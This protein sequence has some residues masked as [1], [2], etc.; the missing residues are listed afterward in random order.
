MTAAAATAAA[1]FIIIILVVDLLFSATTRTTTAF[2]SCCWHHHHHDSSRSNIG[3]S[4]SSSRLLLV[5][6]NN[7]NDKNNIGFEAWVSDAPDETIVPQRLQ[8]NGTIPSYVSGTLLRNGGAIW[9]LDGAN[10]HQL[11]HDDQNNDNDNDKTKNT[12]TQTQKDSYKSAHI[13]DG[14]SKLSRYR[15]FHDPQQ[16]TDKNNNETVVVEFSSRFC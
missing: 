8:V 14:L 6:N 7:H 13:F 11:D 5:H 9:S 16:P 4:S 3:S 15:I 10:R 12:I 1:S 2:S